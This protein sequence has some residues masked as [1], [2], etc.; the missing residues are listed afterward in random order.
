M[1]TERFDVVVV[2]AG[3]AGIMA[4]AHAATSP[5]MPRTLLVTDGPLGR[6]NTVMAQGGIQVPFPSAESRQAML[7][8]MTRSARVAVDLVRVSRFIDAIRGDGVPARGV[9]TGARPRP[10]AAPWCG[11]APAG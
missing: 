7:D 5:G 10:R 2:G 8:D 4:A 9:G 6:A 11:G 1:I 3:A